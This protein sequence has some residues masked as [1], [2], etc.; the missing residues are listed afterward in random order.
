MDLH[1]DAESSCCTLGCVP[2]FLIIISSFTVI[3]SFGMLRINDMIRAK[4]SACKQK[5]RGDWLG[6]FKSLLE[7][8]KK[9][10]SINTACVQ[11]Y[12]LHYTEKIHYI[13]KNFTTIGY[14]LFTSSM[15]ENH[16][17][18]T[19]K[20]TNNIESWYLALLTISITATIATNI[21]IRLLFE[22]I[23]QLTEKV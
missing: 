22:A 2:V 5:Q 23:Q 4:L 1:D 18:W 12:N 8:Y 11:E 17:N 15:W 6:S 19:I 3:S 14:T 20:Y 9:T 10:K 13:K 21:L 7:F 16:W